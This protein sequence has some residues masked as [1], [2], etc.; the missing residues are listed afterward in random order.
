MEN[1]EKQRD[2]R[3]EYTEKKNIYIYMWR[4]KKKEEVSDETEL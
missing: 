4:E 1:I 2:R 3:K